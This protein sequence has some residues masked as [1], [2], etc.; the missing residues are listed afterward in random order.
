MWITT[1]MLAVASWCVVGIA[2][3]GRRFLVD[4]NGIEVRVSGQRL[5]VDAS[6]A[7]DIS[8]LRDLKQRLAA[9]D[10][11]FIAM[12]TWPG[13]YTLFGQKSPTW[14]IYALLPRSPDFESREIERIKSVDP[15]FILIHDH[16]LD[17]RDALQC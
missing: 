13:A 6:T 11:A 7:A 9:A 10:E 1:G 17:G 12:P 16:A 4:G 15:A 8:L 3:P 5:L 14:E 2:H